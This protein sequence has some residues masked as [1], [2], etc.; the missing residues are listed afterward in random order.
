M[1]TL[2]TLF[3][4]L[5][6]VLVLYGLG[7][8]VPGLSPRLRAGLASLIP[9]L[10]Y[11]VL[12][13]A[14]WPGLDV[15]AI[16][17]S[18]FLA[19]GL[20]LASTAGLRRRGSRLHWAPRLL[21]GF[22]VGII[23]LNAGL[24]YIA[25]KGLPPAFAAWWLGGGGTVHSGFSGVVAHGQDAAKAV[26][27]ELSQSHRESRIGWRVAVDGLDGE[28][29][30]RAVRIRVRD[31]TGLPVERIQAELRLL[32]P[33]DTRAAR[34]LALDALDPGVYG[35]VLELPAGG[36]WLAELQLLRDGAL[37][38]RDTLELVAR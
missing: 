24:L 15:A 6:A 14:R 20:V 32:R 29:P 31:R 38:Y 26:S 3:G 30:S 10:G 13:A 33:G 23:V 12:A 7:G 2:A 5:A 17:V 28:S 11:F 19:A 18:V 36:R 21:I 35:G 9:L 8:F 25:T 1:S 22:F 4:G 34:V 37:Q 16:H 27:S